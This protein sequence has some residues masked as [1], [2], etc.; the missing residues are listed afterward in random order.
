MNKKIIEVIAEDNVKYRLTG[1]LKETLEEIQKLIEEH[2]EDARLGFDA[3]YEYYSTE[4]YAYARVFK[5]REETD[6][7]Y[8][9]RTAKERIYQ[10]Q[11]EAQERATFEA[12][13]KKYGPA[14]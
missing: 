12:L 10:E 3:E 6:D 8:M 7:E 11:R 1:S 4:K 9:Q 2:G 13:S 5:K 14:K